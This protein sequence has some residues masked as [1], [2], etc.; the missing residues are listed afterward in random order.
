MGVAGVQLSSHSILITGLAGL[1]E[2]ALGIA[3]RKQPVTAG[4]LCGDVRLSMAILNGL[5][6][7]AREQAGID[8]ID[9]AVVW[10]CS[11]PH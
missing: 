8:A 11:V 9:A 10:G 2:T 4:N 5:L 3:V 7:L 6:H 1:A